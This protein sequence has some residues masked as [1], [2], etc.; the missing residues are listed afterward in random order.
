MIKISAVIITRNEE[1][2]IGR[3]IDSLLPVVDE[4]L[5]VDSFSTDNTK[6]ICEQKGTR[7]IENF[8]K[9]YIEQKNFAVD[10]ITHDYIL[11]IDAD[12]Y[13]SEELSNSILLAKASE[14]Y[15][16]Y[17]MNRLSSYGGKWI[18]HT[19]WYPDEKLRLWHKEYGKWGGPKPHEQ[20]ILNAEIEVKHLKG[21][22]LHIAYRNAEE[23][24]TKANQYSSFFA[25]TSRTKVGSSYAKIAYKTMFAF[26]RNF[27]LH[28][29]VLSGLGGL[30]ISFSNAVYTFFKYSKL[31]ELNRTLP[32]FSSADLKALPNGISVV[33]P[34]YNGT[35]LFPKTL[36]PL[37]MVLKETNLPYEIIVS[38][39]CSTDD[40]IEYLKEQ[41]PEVMVVQGEVNKGFSGACNN[42]I[43]AAQYDLVLL[44]NSDIILT[45]GYF[46]HQ[47]KY[48]QREDTFGVMG[49]II[50]WDDDKIQDAARLPV[51]QGLKVKTS[52]NYLLMPMKE[53]SLYTFYLSGANALVNRKKLIQLGGFDELFSP[54]YIED[55]DLSFRAWRLGWKCYYENKATCRHQTSTTVKVKSKKEYI[56]MIYNRNK[57]FLHAIH[58]KRYQLPFWLLQMLVE[59][60]LRSLAF[61]FS[62]AGSVKL[63]FKNRNQWMESRRRFGKLMKDNGEV[64]SLQ[65]ISRGILES[66]FDRKNVKFYSSQVEEEIYKYE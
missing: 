4:I 8:F 30:Q 6:I 12:E 56:E 62:Y 14:T 24:I 53:E 48:F 15:Y 40:S 5:V 43:H 20:V 29:G 50:G 32:S 26:F 33:I 36:P 25:D 39:D 28:K 52:V 19:D 9:G 35:S 17:T 1:E 21:N 47:L 55:C 51:F 59:L 13:L 37:L 2:N 61:R 38:D 27:V 44:L 66:L 3:C 41:Y 63:F 57:F 7:F 18:W 64:T 22:L 45:S 65:R 11:S 10:F 23:L 42:G 54:F 60:V 58:L 31:L 16:A 49:K 34:N 46:K